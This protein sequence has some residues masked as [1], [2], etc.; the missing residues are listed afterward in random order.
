MV[1]FKMFAGTNVGLRENNEDNFTVCP[2]LKLNEWIVPAQ[3]GQAI[4]LGENGCVMVV[5]DGMGGQNAGEVASAIAVETVQD[6][7]SPVKMPADVLKRPETIKG[8]LKK[9]VAEADARVKAYS[10]THAN[11]EGMGSTIV[12]AWLV[13]SSVYVAWLGDSRAYSYVPGKGIGR[14]SKDHSYVQQLVDAGDL[15]D[16]E[17]MVHPN[18]NIITRSLGDIGQKPKVDVAEYPLMDGEVLLLCSDGLCGYCRDEVIGGIIEQYADNLQLCK[19]KL[20][21]AALAA[22]G[23]DNITI[24]LLRVFTDG[25]SVASGVAHANRDEIWRMRKWLT[26]RNVAVCS[27]G[28]CLLV[29]LCFAG[30]SLFVPDKDENSPV[31]LKLRLDADSIRKGEDVRFHVEG[32]PAC[33]FVYDESLIKINLN[34]ED[35]TISLTKSLGEDSTIWIKAVSENDAEISDSRALILMKEEL[36]HDLFDSIGYEQGSEESKGIDSAEIFDHKRD[37]E[38]GLSRKEDSISITTSGEPESATIQIVKKTA[39]KYNN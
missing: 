15:T 10:T 1:S 25:K 4:P 14:L 26:L 19:E 6:M 29:G 31:S 2:D 20:T 5:A 33:R 39:I 32:N 27:F 36:E 21:D 12:M 35:S 38:K 3:Y 16:E 22:G 11:A 8:F 30:Y 23:S 18:S 28:V 37:V 13:G 9:V 24:A 7:F 17:A 34:R